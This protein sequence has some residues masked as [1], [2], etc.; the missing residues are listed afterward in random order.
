MIPLIFSKEIALSPLEGSLAYCKKYKR[1]IIVLCLTLLIVFSRSLCIAEAPFLRM[2]IFRTGGSVNFSGAK[3]KLIPL[4]SSHSI[5]LKKFIKQYNGANLLKIGPTELGADSKLRIE[6]SSGY[7]KIN[8]AV[9]KSRAELYSK[10]G[11]IL[12]IISVLRLEEYLPGIIEAEIPASW[13]LE[14]KKAQAVAARTYTLWKMAASKGHYHI[15]AG[16]EDQVYVG[17]HTHD[18]EALQ[19]VSETRG[20]YMAFGGKPVLAYYH[21]CCGGITDSAM[22]IKKRNLKYIRPVKCHWCKDSP[23]RTWTY[24][25]QVKELL[26]RLK[27]AGYALGELDTIKK[28]TS[29]PGNRINELEFIG[30]NNSIIIKAEELRKILGY[31]DL[32]SSRF[33]IHRQGN[34]YQFVGSGYGHGLGACQYGFKGMADSGKNY[35]EML[36]YY[37]KGIEFKKISD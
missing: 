2:L 24:E 21:S 36:K 11:K 20:E 6:S 35:K 32:R 28:L 30:S 9:F 7:L 19:A 5:K 25:I 15:V 27:A 34:L 23:K 22:A 33:K 13:P 3:L 17:K 8:G 10:D 1:S 29:T 18:Q 4:K 12:D 26:S 37:Y 16:V 14:S 31:M